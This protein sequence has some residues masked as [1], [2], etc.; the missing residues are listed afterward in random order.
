MSKF[1]KSLAPFEW[2][3][4][5]PNERVKLFCVLFY[6][7]NTVWQEEKATVSWTMAS[8]PHGVSLPLV[9]CRDP[10]TEDLLYSCKRPL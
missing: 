2:L 4:T 6:C 9:D 5:Q 1:D 7:A 8:L 10:E 3:H